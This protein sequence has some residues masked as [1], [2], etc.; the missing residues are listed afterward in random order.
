MFERELA[1]AICLDK[2]NQEFA[3]EVTNTDRTLPEWSAGWGH[4]HFPPVK[5]VSVEE[6]AQ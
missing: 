2:P 6:S 5:V 3:F 4:I 1:G